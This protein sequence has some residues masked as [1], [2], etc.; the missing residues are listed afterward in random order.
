MDVLSVLWHIMH[1]SA[2]AGQPQGCRWRCRS[3]ARQVV[4]AHPVCDQAMECTHLAALLQLRPTPLAPPALLHPHT[5]ACTNCHCAPICAWLL[6]PCRAAPCCR[7]PAAGGGGRHGPSRAQGQHIADVALA[8]TVVLCG[9]AIGAL[10]ACVAKRAWLGPRWTLPFPLQC[11][12]GAA[13]CICPGRTPRSCCKGTDWVALRVVFG[14]QAY[15]SAM[16]GG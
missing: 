12:V 5:P 3:C 13:V 11:S 10:H 2:V 8:I 7:G 4:S 1:A 14:T 16:P 9:P 15:I 6:T